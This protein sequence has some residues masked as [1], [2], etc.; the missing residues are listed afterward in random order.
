MFICIIICVWV[1]FNNNV[2]F[3]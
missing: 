2:A 1:L 3:V